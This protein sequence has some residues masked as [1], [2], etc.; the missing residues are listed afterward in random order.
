MR[1]FFVNTTRK[2]GGGEKWHLE[3]AV[4]MKERGHDV[5]I[6]ANAGS[7]LFQ[8]SYSS[9]IRTIPIHVTN[10]SFLNPYSILS[11]AGLLRKENP[12]VIILNFSADVKTVGMAAKI[13]GI[14][15]IIY[16]RGSAIPIRNTFLNRYLY[17]N[18]ITRIIANSLATRNTILQNNTKLFP[19][20]KIDVIYNGFNIREFDDMPKEEL[21]E[22]QGDEVIIGNVG[23]LVEQKGQ[24]YLIDLAVVL[25]QKDIS[26]RILIAGEGSLESSLKQSA[27]DAGVSERIIFM[28]FIAN[29]KAF[30]DNIDI[31]VLPSLWEGFGY[32]LAEAMACKKPVVAFNISSN[33]EIID[34]DVTGFLVSHTN[35]DEL[36]EKVEMLIRN[37]NLRASFGLAGR[38][39]VETVFNI[40]RTE[41]NIEELLK[42]L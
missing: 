29:T 4:A 39:R 27:R 17:K 37:P 34:R 32:V 25:A 7:D 5:A 16:R 6:L 23:R 33:P 40:A 15:N 22:R 36:A 11:I 12:N 8:R 41:L 38:R 42:D 26:Y 10:F 1:I 24:K 30:M 19:P 20:D 14:P 28:G 35:I 31:F 2:W 21:Y 13:A 3:T 9:G 18:I